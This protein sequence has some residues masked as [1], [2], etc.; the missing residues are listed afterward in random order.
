MLGTQR[1]LTSPYKRTRRYTC[2]LGKGTEFTEA[3]STS[4]HLPLGDSAAQPRLEARCVGRGAQAPC[5]LPSKASV[6]HLSL[7]SVVGKKV[8]SLHRVLQELNFQL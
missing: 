4:G 3:K 6:Q 5:L 1:I 8:D 2:S 7:A